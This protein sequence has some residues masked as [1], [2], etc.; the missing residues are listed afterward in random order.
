MW[1]TAFMIC[2]QSLSRYIERMPGLNSGFVSAH[3]GRH[4]GGKVRLGGS[5]PSRTPITH[6]SVS[7]WWYYCV[8]RIIARETICFCIVIVYSVE[9]GTSSAT[10]LIQY[11][12]KLAS[13]T[14]PILPLSRTAEVVC[15]CPNF[16]TM[17]MVLDERVCCDC[18]YVLQG[19][20]CFKLLFL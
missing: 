15:S 2:Q 18:A 14:L 13:R 3:L 9:C 4:D 12:V 17:L 19:R 10:Y 16:S 7:C 6:I 8:C 11:N 20:C 1:V 5:S